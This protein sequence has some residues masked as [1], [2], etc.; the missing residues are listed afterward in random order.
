MRST[1]NLSAASC[2]LGLSITLFVS[3]CSTNLFSGAKHGHLHKVKADAPSKQEVVKKHEMVKP[4]EIVKLPVIASAA[5]KPEIH[6]DIANDVRIAYPNTIVRGD[7]DL[8]LKL[9]TAKVE[10]KKAAEK[11][12]SVSEAGTKESGTDGLAIAGFVCSLV[13]LFVAG[14]LLGILGIIFS[15]IAL[16]RI[17]KTGKK[18]KGLAIAG[19]IIGI[20]AVV[21][22]VI[23]IAAM[24]P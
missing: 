16:S 11:S 14:V 8:E 15:A 7:K 23:V 2:M 1:M 20:L 21:G 12:K 18:G 6:N 13:G 5:A 10:P 24:Y 17:S 4:V 9:E 3:S 19:L 22:A